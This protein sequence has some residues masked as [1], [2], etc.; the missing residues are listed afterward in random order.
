MIVTAGKQRNWNER[1]TANMEMIIGRNKSKS[2]RYLKESDQKKRDGL[3]KR[4]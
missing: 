4:F 3:E 2:P 1:A